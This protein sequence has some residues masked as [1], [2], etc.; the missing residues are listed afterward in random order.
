M[1]DLI[2]EFFYEGI[3]R[4]VP[5]IAVIA[6]YFHQEVVKLFEAHHLLFFVTLNAAILLIAWLVGFMVEQIM[7]FFSAIGWILGGERSLRK[8]RKWLQN[9]QSQKS[10]SRSKPA[11]DNDEHKRELRR[12]GYLYFAEKTM[13]RSLWP[14][15]LVSGIHPPES[16]SNFPNVVPHLIYWILA[17]VFLASWL[18]AVTNDRQ[19]IKE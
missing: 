4:I 12:Q 9:G 10:E 2:S 3:R 16:F 14:I 15:F 6:L 7:A 8:I 11:P 18:R 19:L 5:G 1:N 13:C 17:S